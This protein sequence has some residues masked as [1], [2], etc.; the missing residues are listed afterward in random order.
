MQVWIPKFWRS[1]GSHRALYDH[2]SLLFPME[3]RFSFQP[4]MSGSHFFVSLWLESCLGEKEQEALVNNCLN[5]NTIQLCARVAKK[6]SGILACVRNSVARR[7]RTG[8]VPLYPALLRSHFEYHVQF[9]IPYSKKDT[10]VLGHVQRWATGLVKS[11]EHKSYKE[12]LRGLG[13]F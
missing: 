8:I 12:C 9:W 13:F 1:T 2:C 5:M 6:T 7:V 10:E 11:L 3:S 4:N